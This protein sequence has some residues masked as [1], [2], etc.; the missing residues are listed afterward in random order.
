MTI[1]LNL[2]IIIAVITDKTLRN[3]TNIQFA[4]MSC[5]DLLVGSIAMPSMLILTLYGHWPLGDNLCIVFIL[6]DFIG[7]NISIVTLTII[8]HHRLRCIQR[9]YGMKKYTTF[10]ML[11][12]AL[13]IWPLVIAFWTLPT[14]MIIKNQKYRSMYN[15]LRYCYFIFSFEYVLLVDL[16]AYV[17]PICMLIYFQVSIYF[18]LKSKKNL[19]KPIQQKNKLLTKLI[20][21]DNTGF[22]STSSSAITQNLLNSNNLFNKRA[23]NVEDDTSN[24]NNNNSFYYNNQP[25]AK[26][27]S[28][29]FS[30][31]NS[32]VNDIVGELQEKRL[33]GYLERKGSEE[34]IK[35]STLPSKATAVRVNS[36]NQRTTNNKEKF[37][38]ALRFRLFKTQLNLINQ[39]ILL[40]NNYTKNK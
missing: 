33:V 10:E 19:I 29:S 39:Q 40:T 15:N 36:V 21:N 25:V 31:E 12:P 2:F 24:S 16:I 5:A 13:I 20:A 38:K 37:V 4:S 30:E 35:M 11:L 8:S 7:G 9:P 1:A 34:L 18:A 26:N 22:G 23:N 6:G 28:Q 32:Q 27:I 17:V 14:M 3:F